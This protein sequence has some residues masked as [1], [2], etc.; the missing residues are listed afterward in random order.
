M[1]DLEWNNTPQPEEN[2]GFTSPPE[3][4]EMPEIPE[5]P[6]APEMPEIPEMPVIP[7]APDPQAAFDAAQAQF[8]TPPE[9]A[10]PV[11]N[12]YNPA[13]YQQPP[14]T[15]PTQ[16]Q[17]QY[18]Y[19]PPQ[20]DGQN[21]YGAPQYGAPQY[22]ENPYQ[23]TYYAQQ[24]YA[25]QQGQYQYNVPPM[26]YQQKSRMAAG[27]LGIFLG[28]LGIHNFYLGFNTRAIIQLVVYL[29]GGL[30]TCGVASVAM[31]IW[32]LVEGIMIL[33]GS[34]SRMYDSNNVILKD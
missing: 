33:S 7:T 19:A 34:A 14:Y 28:G 3:T 18:Q 16:E 27:L 6:K 12:G 20:Q 30:I 24:P 17:P 8:P 9:P 25:Q 31:A 5:L 2:P 32:G 26:G 15:P 13:A 4:P 10:A 11:N 21:Q 29:A 1:T 22:Q 23:Q